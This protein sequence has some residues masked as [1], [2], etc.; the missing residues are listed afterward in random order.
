[1]IFELRMSADNLT[2]NETYP[3]WM[4]YGLWNVIIGEKVWRISIPKKKKKKSIE[5]IV[6]KVHKYRWSITI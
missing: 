5:M 2:S 1:M 6:S 4:V 3:K